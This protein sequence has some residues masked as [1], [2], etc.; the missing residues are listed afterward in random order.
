MDA[1]ERFAS[2]RIARL[3]TVGLGSVPHLVPIVFALDSGTIYS[4]VDHKPKRTTALRRLQ[5]IAANPAVSV[6]VDH[7]DE[8]W[9][10]LWWVCA[11]GRAEILDAGTPECISAIDILAAKYSQ[12]VERRPDGP[13]IAVRD[14]Q[15]HHWSAL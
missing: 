9:D 1:V 12:Y 3:A 13:V 2:A 5:N 8:N 14:L 10:Q 4:S 15:W 6:L 11:N 7:Y